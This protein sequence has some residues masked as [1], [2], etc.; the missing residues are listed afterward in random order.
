MQQILNHVRNNRIRRPDLVYKCAVPLL[1]RGWLGNAQ[2]DIREQLFLAALDLHK[3]DLAEE[4]FKALS[5]RFPNSMR[6]RGLEGM[7]YEAQATSMALM[8]EQRMQLAEKAMSIYEDIVAEDP[9]SVTARKR[10]V[11]ALRSRGTEEDMRLAIM[12]L[13]E[14]LNI[15][16]TDGD[17]W[18]E[19][20]EMY[21]EQQQLESARKALEEVVMLQ[22]VS[23]L[24][25]L[26]LAEVLYS[27]DKYA[28][29]RKYYA[30]SL[31][32]NPHKNP[33]AS[34]GM[35]LCT[36]AIESP[37]SGKSKQGDETN[38]QLFDLSRQMVLGR[39]AAL[40]PNAPG[41]SLAP[42]VKSWLGA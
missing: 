30:Q 40:K 16:P 27:L 24:P 33:R 6:V 15:Y 35:L 17:G 26:K 3:F 8:E 18:K 2:W 20:A 22:P 11:A 28:L 5:T 14:Y 25:H 10:K 1:S 37:K 34:L 32:L 21:L 36:T 7:K 31:E 9:C 41:A 39:Y 19:L 13:N 4:Q 42:L 12:S 29:A 38:T 23:Y